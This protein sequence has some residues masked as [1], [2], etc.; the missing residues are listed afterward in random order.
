MST[1]TQP[2]PAFHVMT[3][4]IGARCNLNCEYC[5]YLSKQALYAGERSRMSDEVLESYLC[6]LITAHRTPEVTVAWQGGEPTLM[7]LDFFRRA[8]A[9]EERYRKPGMVI[10]NTL[11]TNGT[12]LDDEWCAFFRAHRFL[13]GVSLDGPPEMHDAFRLDR[14]GKP[15]AG[16]VVEGIRLLQKHGVE[17]NILATVNA[18][19][20]GHPLEVFRYLRDEIGAEFIQFIPIVERSDQA[21]GVSHRSVTAEQWGQF[22]I[23]VFDE[24]VRRDVGSVYVQIFDAALA[25]WAGVPSGLCMFSETCGDALA[26][27]RNGDLYACDHFVDPEHLLG[28]IQQVQLIDLVGSERQRAFGRQKREA[29]PPDCRRCP[30]RFACHGECPKNRFIESASGEPGLNYLCAG[31]RAFFTHIDEPMRFMASELRANR[32]PSNVMAFLAIRS[33]EPIEARLRRSGS[34]GAS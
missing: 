25:A 6:Q 29:L 8:V 5:F 27:E 1:A 10:Q 31:Y 15:T 13:I 18:A 22:L 23:T 30:V 20:A 16:R 4:P 21:T 2:M 26:L 14:R 28:N 9:I 19:N 12:V 33:S 11:Q 32:A 7:G 3:K 24:W 34:G 17:F